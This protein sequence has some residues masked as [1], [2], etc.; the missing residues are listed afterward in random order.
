[1]TLHLAQILLQAGTGGACGLLTYSIQAG[2]VAH[3]LLQC[4]TSPCPSSCQPP[5]QVLKQEG[6]EC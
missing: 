6:E 2:K 1:M 4:E 5:A 3:S